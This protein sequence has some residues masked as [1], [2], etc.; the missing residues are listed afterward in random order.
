M[1]IQQQSPVSQ[2]FALAHASSPHWRIALAEC[3][4]QLGSVPASSNLGF[5]YVTDHYATKLSDLLEVLRSRTG[6]EHWVGSVGLGVCATGQEYLDQGAVVVML[7]AFEPDSFRVLS[8]LRVANDLAR[9]PLTIGGNAGNFAIV[10]GDP[11]NN[12]IPSMIAEISRRLESGFVVGGL[13]GSRSAQVQI[14]NGVVE[15][16]LS[17]VVFDD[18]VIVSTRLTQGCAPIG[19]MHAVTESQRNVLIQLDGRPALDVLREDAGIKSERE[20]DRVGG[21]VFAALPIS[22]SNADDYTVR[23]LVG[24][25]T[26]RGLVAI[27]DSV[28]QGG[29]IMFCRRDRR[30]ATDDMARMLES[31]KSGLYTRPRGGLYFSCVGRGKSLFGESSKE[32]SMIREALGEVPIAGFFCSGEI[33]HNRLYGYTGVLTLF[34]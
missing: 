20:L 1:S 19:Q 14:A 13:S 21:M 16:G 27:G 4:E 31:I 12:A 22:G 29:K 24:L 25:D 26:E 18:R 2:V 17:G 34:L 15:G 6:I 7:G 30:A 3:M 28:R 8:T 33:S 5:V 23:S 9:D 11:R 10:H 32:L